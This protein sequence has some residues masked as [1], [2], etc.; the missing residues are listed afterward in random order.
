[1]Q[2]PPENLDKFFE[3]YFT[4]GS[5]LA[6]E[7]RFH[8]GVSKTKYLILL[9]H[10]PSESETLFFL[11]TS[12]V[13][14]YKKHPSF[15]DHI[16]I[17]PGR[18]PFFSLETVINCNGVHSIARQELKSRY[19]ERKLNIVGALSADIMARIDQIVAASRNI[20]PRHKK[21]ILGWK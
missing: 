9:N 4:R 2:I 7:M 21:S 15:K 12:Q 20:S 13:D 19:R 6:T 14:F 17:T 5:V 16:I 11:T 3:R 1:M 18:F 10:D 8:S